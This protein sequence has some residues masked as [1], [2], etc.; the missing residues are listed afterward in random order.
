MQDPERES[1][2]RRI[3]RSLFGAVG[4]LGEQ[5]VQHSQM[6]DVLARRRSSSD[7]TR[8]AS[9]R[10]LISMSPRRTVVARAIS[11]E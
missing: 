3:G 8:S 4:E 9:A 5:L 11:A 7:R 1:R 6:L 2:L 10:T